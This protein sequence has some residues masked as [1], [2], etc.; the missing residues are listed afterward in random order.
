MAVSSSEPLPPPGTRLDLQADAQHLGLDLSERL[1]TE[2]RRLGLLGAPRRRKS[3]PHGQ[4]LAE[5]S[6][7]Q[8]DLFR[9]VVRSRLLGASNAALANLPVY[10]WLNF[11]EEW[12]DTAQVRLAMRT[13]VG[14]DPRRSERA[15]AA[16]A[17]G[18]LDSIDVNNAS[19][20]ARAAFKREVTEQLRKGRI[21]LA[22]LHAVVTRVFQPGDVVIRRG[23]RD[24]MLHVDAITSIVAARM[25]AAGKLDKITN[26]QFYQVRLRHLASWGGY[27]QK[28]W[29]RQQEAGP[30]LAHLYNDL[31]SE[32]QAAQAVGTL[33]LLL[34]YVLAEQPTDRARAAR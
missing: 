12:V 22:R 7:E 18:L 4:D 20:R 11:G 5:F 6:S 31:D 13:A 14:K 32:S 19:V 28:G 33:L 17:R 30:Q 27:A 24:A 34:G 10:A 1:I 21:D 9:A 8:R 23:P 26:E 25:T 16:T 29:Q 15:A 3:G 2:W